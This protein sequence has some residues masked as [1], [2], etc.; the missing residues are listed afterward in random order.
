M[1]NTLN[2]ATFSGSTLYIKD[3]ICTVLECCVQIYN[4]FVATNTKVSNNEE[5]IRDV[6]FDKLN[7]DAYRGKYPSLQNYH[8][9]RE[10]QE[11]TGFVDIKVKTLN[12]YRSTKAYYCI[13]C[14]RLDGQN[15]TGKSGLNAEYIKNGICRFV[16]GY[17]STYFGCNVMFGFVVKAL[18]IQSSVVVC[19]NQIINDDFTNSQS[20]TVNARAT[21][22]MQ[23]DNYVNGYPYSYISKHTKDD[24]NEITLYHLMFD[25]SNNIV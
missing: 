24:G 13:E 7:D 1:S 3:E 10:P 17:Y 25:F 21:V 16:S 11:N 4:Q 2:A 14:K 20:Q 22:K 5:K 15:L 12:P 18:N 9:E 8:F 19:I 6:F 23:Y